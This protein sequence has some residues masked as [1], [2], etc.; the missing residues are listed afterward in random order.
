MYVILKLF[1]A[2][3]VVVLAFP[4][5]IFGGIGLLGN[6]KITFVCWGIAAWGALEL[7]LIFAKSAE[8]RPKI[9][10][11]I[12]RTIYGGTVAIVL[13]S[14]VESSNTDKSSWLWTYWFL[15]AIL[16]LVAALL[17]RLLMERKTSQRT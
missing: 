6:L 10:G 12:R 2:I 9:S 1:E 14:L 7:L 15:L 13:V 3:A 11:S 16:P 8:D 17:Y 5:L 4:L